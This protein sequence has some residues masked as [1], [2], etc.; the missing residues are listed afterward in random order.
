MTRTSPLLLTLALAGLAALAGA[1]LH[2]WLNQDSTRASTP[3]ARDATLAPPFTLPDLE[4]QMRSLDDWRGKVVVLNFW[5]TW[6]PPCRHEIPAFVTLQDRLGE[7]GVQFVGIALDEADK[8]REFAASVGINYPTLIGGADAIP[9]GRAY[10]NSMGTLPFTAI[11]DRAGQL[12]YTR[13]G[14]LAPTQ[15]EAVLA[16]L[17]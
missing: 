7:R 15:A 9:L 17:L 13:H 10:G 2:H 11:I 6:C 5:A 16:P 3:A 14:E 8:V 1:G 4:Q 12:V